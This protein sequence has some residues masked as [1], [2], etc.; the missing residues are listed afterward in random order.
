MIIQI[1]TYKNETITFSAGTRTITV[2][3]F[4]E[5]F[6]PSNI[7]L[8]TVNREVSGVSTSFV[9][10]APAMWRAIIAN[11]SS[12]VFTITYSDGLSALEAD[13]NIFIM[14]DIQDPTYD[15][16]LDAQKIINQTPEWSHYV[17]QYELFDASNT[18]AGTQRVVAYTESYKNHMFGIVGT[19]GT[20]NTVTITF[21]VPLKSTCVDT[22]DVNWKDI[23]M[24][25]TGMA[26]I[27][28]D[29]TT[30][31]FSDAYFID[32]D[33]IFERLMVKIVLTN[34][35]TASN[36]LAVSHKMS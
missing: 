1:G 27:V 17:D 25:L 10:A 18:A 12:G 3:N 13:D 36:T 24:L 22:D 26:S 16:S 20:N 28:I 15:Y 33:I 30:T 2:S 11:P 29:S 34:S 19:V 9:I 4:Y 21:Q 7:K 6:T 23:T 31:P 5:T 14:V 8:I 35:G 32:T